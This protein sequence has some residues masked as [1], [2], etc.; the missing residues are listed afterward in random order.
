MEST[1]PPNV[2]QRA[3]NLATSIAVFVADGCRTVDSPEYAERLGICNQCVERHESICKACGCYLPIKAGWRVM[4]CP[5]GKWR[6]RPL[7]GGDTEGSPRAPATA[8]QP[9]HDEMRTPTIQ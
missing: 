4:E 6:S 1:R 9:D 2:A 7:P 5:L 3:W 8:V